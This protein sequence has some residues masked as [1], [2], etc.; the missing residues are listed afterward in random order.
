MTCT[1]RPARQTW[2][3][4]AEGYYP[5][6]T[7]NWSAIKSPATARQSY[8]QRRQHHADGASVQTV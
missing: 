2:C 8:L 3:L 1:N 4:D 7:P 5:F 6:E